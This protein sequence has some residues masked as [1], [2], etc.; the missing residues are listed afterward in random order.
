[1]IPTSLPAMPLTT[2]PLAIVVAE[3]AQIKRRR[4]ARLHNLEAHKVRVVGRRVWRS[5]VESRLGLAVVK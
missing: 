5:N 1:M 4:E 2:G 3:L